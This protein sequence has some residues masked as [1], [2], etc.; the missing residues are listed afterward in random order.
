MLYYQGLDHN[1]RPLLIIPFWLNWRPFFSLQWV[2]SESI[3]GMVLIPI[4]D[5]ENFQS[6]YFWRGEWVE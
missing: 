5:N 3:F 1:S 4:N 2:F 6:F